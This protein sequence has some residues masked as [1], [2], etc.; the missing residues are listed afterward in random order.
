MNKDRHYYKLINRLER[1]ETWAKYFIETERQIEISDKVTQ[2][3]GKESPVIHF[4]ANLVMLPTIC[5]TFLKKVLV[6]Q[7]YK[8]CKKEI[9][10]LRKEIE[11]YE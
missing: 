5:L 4:V 11:K 7:S 3:L 10:I 1:A 2:D 6:W 9:E 8:K